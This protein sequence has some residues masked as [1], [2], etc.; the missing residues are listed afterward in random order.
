MNTPLQIL[1]CRPH[2]SAEIIH[3]LP[4]D[5]GLQ[6]QAYVE[7]VFGKV[8]RILVVNHLVLVGPPMRTLYLWVGQIREHSLG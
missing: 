2:G 3:A 6:L 4:L 1:E 5:R 8:H 7:A